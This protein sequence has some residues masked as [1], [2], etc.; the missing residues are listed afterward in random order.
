MNTSSPPTDSLFGA[1][2]QETPAALAAALA[3]A[4][5]PGH[6]DELRGAI[7]HGSS[8]ARH[9]A[10]HGL[11]V[12]PWA[13]FFENLGSDGF[14]D[15]NRRSA[16]LQR[17][18][19]DNGVTYNA[20]A[21]P[22]N[23]QRPWSLDLFP[24]IVPAQSWRQIEAGVLQ[25][26]RL[27]DRVLADVYGAQHLLASGLLPPA[28]VQGH[29]GY[30]RAM[31]GVVPPGGTHLHIAAFDLAHGP[32]GHWSVL[33]QRTQAASGLGYLLENRIAVSRLFPDAF[34]DLKVRRL[35]GTYRALVDGL[36]ALAPGGGEARI[37]LLTPGPHHETYFEHAYLARFLGLALVE[38][39]D[40][41]VR[42][43]RLY[44][45]T[46]R[47]LEPVHA[48]IKRLDDEFL[49]PLELRADS[50]LG[51]PGLL[52]AVRA[53][54]VLV[55]NAPG[56][57]LL[58]STGLLGFL[59][60]LARHL[61]GEDLKLP[62]V[63]TWWCGERA[64][65]EAVLPQLAGGV[66][67]PTYGGG[68]GA[69][70]GRSLSA[71]ELDE[72]A[73][74]IQRDPDGH[75]VQA[76]LPLSQMPTWRQAPQGDRIVPRSLVL[77]VFAVCDGPGSWCVLPGG[78]TRIAAPDLEIASMLRGGSSADT[79]VLADGEVDRSTPVQF[80]LAASQPHEAHS[81][82][83]RAA[84]SLFWLG[85][86]TER[87][88]NTARFAR[89]ALEALTGEDQTSQPLLAWLGRMAGGNGL[90]PA[91]VP[92]PTQARRVFERAL[93]AALGD[94]VHATSVGFNLAHL[95][96]AASTVRERLS[97][98]HWNVIVR[99]GEDFAQGCA[100]LAAQA[101]VSPL[102]ALPLLEAVSAATAA[103]TGAQVD[104]MTRDDGWQL[105]S[106]GRHLERL[107]FLASAVVAALDCGTLHD[108]PGFEAVVSLFDSTI[109]FHAQYQQRHELPA[110]VAL[111]VLDRADPRSLAWVAR[112]LRARLAKL[113]AAVG[114]DGAELA[115]LVPDPREW[116]PAATL[117]ANDGAL[118]SLMVDCV[119]G[120]FRLS[121]ALS[122][123]YFTHVQ[124]TQHSVGA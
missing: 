104:R 73:A 115:N 84:E 70:S 20:Y 58:E 18:L 30:L 9:G 105:L 39:A 5:T 77:R 98:E 121:D 85:R 6:F 4:A 96:R 44:L 118:R 51:V 109:R 71:R 2:P 21:D 106:A 94:G 102:D 46:L 54:N 52:Q 11:P 29:P 43:R 25:R 90:V 40:L 68:A 124:G 8:P 78:L 22:R 122:A 41:T 91:S 53:G 100:A 89:V 57:A 35:A 38:G 48:V 16:A 82:T 45:K 64:A 19:H 50:R 56:S 83:S 116:P 112:S 28:L 101:A 107:A 113:A 67:K 99:A 15:L 7:P 24:L 17:Q 26:V 103:I 31:H 95:Q 36:R 33:S 72:W 1:D 55:A 97:Q 119:D 111:A 42:D 10:P 49:D 3:L 62:S 108:A 74:R 63:P 123:R 23:P 86:Y 87:T 32:D 47:G 37:V 13:R 61:L 66:I 80:P 59:P 27:L 93:I 110:L 117:C 81:T 34:R 60:A 79:W 114:A 88:E 65:C 14:N 75:T 76:W 120:A 12:R 92:S 69:V